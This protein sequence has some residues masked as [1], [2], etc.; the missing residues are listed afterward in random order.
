[1][2]ITAAGT[3]API[4]MAANAKPA[5]QPGNSALKRAGTTSLLLE[6]VKPAA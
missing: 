1:M 6:S 2:L 5:N 4:A 3:R